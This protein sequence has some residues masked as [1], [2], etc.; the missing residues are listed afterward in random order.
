MPRKT[1][2]EPV[3]PLGIAAPPPPPS[4]GPSDW[5]LFRSQNKKPAD[6]GSGKWDIVRGSNFLLCPSCEA[7]A[8]GVL[9][10]DSGVRLGKGASYAGGRGENSPHFFFPSVIPISSLCSVC[11]C[12]TGSPWQLGEMMSWGPQ[13]QAS[14]ASLITKTRRGHCEDRTPDPPVLTVLLCLTTPK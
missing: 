9:P 2:P 7:K 10:R 5:G 14:F 12:S 1:R 11:G 6:W 4:P 13:D 8:T 3:P